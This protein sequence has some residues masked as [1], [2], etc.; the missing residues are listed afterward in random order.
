MYEDLFSDLISTVKRTYKKFELE[1]SQEVEDKM[2]IYLKKNKQEK[3]GRHKY[4]LEKY[5]FA[6]EA[7][8]Q[9][10]EGYMEKYNYGIPDKFR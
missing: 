8:Y 4:T 6:A 7:F 10:Y 1:S 2:K 3:Y 5:G 9:E